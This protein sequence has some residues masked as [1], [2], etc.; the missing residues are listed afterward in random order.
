MNDFERCGAWILLWSVFKFA[1]LAE[2]CTFRP[3]SEEF[4]GNTVGFN[5]FVGDALRRS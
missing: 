4:G 2:V 3:L 5:G 1:E